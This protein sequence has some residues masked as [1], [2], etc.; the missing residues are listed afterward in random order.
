MRLGIQSSFKVCCCGRLRF[1][2]GDNRVIRYSLSMAAIFESQ[3][4]ELESSLPELESS[5]EVE[6]SLSYLLKS[7]LRMT[8]KCLR[9]SYL[10]NRHYWLLVE[11]SCHHLRH[12]RHAAITIN[13]TP[14]GL[15]R[16]FE[17]P[18]Y[19]P[20]KKNRPNGS[21][22]YQLSEPSYVNANE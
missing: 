9:C 8:M 18:F 14:K 20:Q 19:S 2:I 1:I 15:M 12:R 10:K 21:S 13:K 22:Y 11:S 17:L 7:L 6:N 5:L 16:F 3:E 4:P